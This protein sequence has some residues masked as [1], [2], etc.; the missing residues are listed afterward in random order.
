MLCNTMTILLR[1]MEGTFSLPIY[2]WIYDI[3]AHC[4]FKE[5]LYPMI[6]PFIKAS[7]ESDIVSMKTSAQTYGRS[8]SAPVIVV[9]PVVKAGPT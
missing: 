9:V 3:L 7:P 2:I 4:R 8:A 6:V 5:T 1:K